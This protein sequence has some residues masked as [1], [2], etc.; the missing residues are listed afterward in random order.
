MLA[1]HGGVPVRGS[2]AWPSWPHCDEMTEAALLL[3]LRSGR[4]TVSWPSQGSEAL[5]RRF[6]RAFAEYH[7]PDALA[8]AVDHG[9]SA[10]VVALEALDIGPGDEVIVPA[11]TWV[12]TASAVLR[13]GALPV[14]AD[15]DAQT[16]CL[17]PAAVKN[18]LSERTRAVIVVHLACTVADLPVLVEVTDAA[19]IDLIEDCAQSHGAR[20]GDRLVGTF[21]R[22]GC[23]SF[24]QG[25][26]LS[27]G[28]GGA[29]VVREESLFERLQALR[30]DSRTYVPRPPAPGTIEIDIGSGL[31]GANYCM[32]D[33]HAALLLDQ[34]PRLEAQRLH[35]EKRATELV[36]AISH[37][38]VVSEVP[39][40]DGWKRSIYEY[41][42]QFDLDRL[43]LPDTRS[44][45]AALSAEL[46]LAVYPP[47]ALLNDSP[48]LRPRSKRRFSAWWSEEHS[49]R[50]F[51]RAFPGAEAYG[52]TTVLMHHAA[53]LGTSQ[54]VA[55]LAAAVEKVFAHRTSLH[56]GDA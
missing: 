45:A 19:G 24:Q 12:A 32:S 48:L 36:E 5:E 20:W 13:V 11:A 8:V 26:A 44:V 28:E 46:G 23:F 54:D 3:A 51:D 10:L 49:R 25:K 22:V 1:I 6:A 50:A 41:G 34:L 2:V 4:L 15:V 30:A 42:L 52:R 16:G 43:G 56:P 33:L 53:L 31:T 40:P 47:D 27:G 17:S 14:L 55:D 29:V 21:G 37:L 7:G 9:S 35:R 39:V 38:N 18:L